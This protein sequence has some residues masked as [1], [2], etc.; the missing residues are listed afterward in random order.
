MFKNLFI[1]FFLVFL[2]FSCSKKEK[3]KITSEPTELEIAIAIY[4]EAL[5]A[6]KKGD[7]YYAGTKFKEVENLLPQSKWATKASLMA[8]Y[9]EYSRNTYSNAIFAFSFFEQENNKKTEKNKINKFLNISD[10]I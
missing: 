2:L 1:L 3:V 10:K 7:A 5:E 9:S 8:A 6:L 4:G